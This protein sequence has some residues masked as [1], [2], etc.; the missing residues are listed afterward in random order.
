MQD[1]SV[2]SGSAAYANEVGQLAS[3]PRS[4]WQLAGVASP[5]NV[6]EHSHR[7][8]VLAYI[9]AAQ[10]GGN[11]DRACTLGVFHDVPETRVGDLHS[12][13]KRYLPDPA[14][15]EVALDQVSDLPDELG[16]RIV[17]LV[18]EFESAKQPD[19]S[20]E[21]RCARD[22]DKIECLLTAREYQ[23]QGYRRLDG[24]IDTM[25]GAVTT[26]TGKALA[27]EMLHVE[28][29]AWWSSIVATYR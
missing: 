10:E 12:M 28:P 8:A 5:Q 1:N 4:G 18:D 26:E 22:A 7:V 13:H 20:L 2:P 14:P 19:S 3:T 27:Q 11:P 24:W 17:A 29:G 6:A 23:A 9:I 25:S 21:A 16:R 15:H